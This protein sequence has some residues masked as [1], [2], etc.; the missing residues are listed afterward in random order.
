MLQFIRSVIFNIVFFGVTTFLCFALLWTLLLPRKQ[1]LSVYNMYF[2]MVYWME[3]LILGLDVKIEGLE[4]LPADNRYIIAAKHQSAHETMI[5][6]YTLNDPAII[7]KK[8]LMN[9]PFWGWYARKAGMI[10][11]DRS[12][13]GSALKSMLEGA[14]R[15]F[16]EGRPVLI[17]PQGT[18]TKLTDTTANRPY[19]RGISKIYEGLNCPV[20]PMALNTGVFWGR[21]AFIKKSG[22]ATLKFLPPIEAGLSGD[23]M[24]HRLEEALEPASTQLVDDALAMHEKQANRRALQDIAAFFVLLFGLWSAYWLWAADAV[25]KA[26]LELR[27]DMQEDA[28]LAISYGDSY[29]AGF[30]FRLRLHIEDIKLH[31]PT[32]TAHIPALEAHAVPLPDYPLTIESTAPITLSPL[33]GRA[34]GQKFVIDSLRMQIAHVIPAPFSDLAAAES[35]YQLRSMEIKSGA[36]SIQAQGH[37]HQDPQTLITNGHILFMLDGYQEYVQDLIQDGAVKAT[38]ALF[39][40]TMLQNQSAQWRRQ[41]QESGQ[42]LPANLAD[43]ALILPLSIKDNVVYAGM[44]RIGRIGGEISD[45]PLEKESG[46]G[47]GY[48]NGLPDLPRPPQD[49]EE[50]DAIPPYL[51]DKSLQG[52]DMPP[53]PAIPRND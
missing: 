9:I 16:A 23:E 2:R 3:R 15:V 30:P 38:P 8:E 24:M 35:A 13:R 14:R 45:A 48:N 25:E 28:P 39:F 18:R 31:S 22:T 20:V 47:T 44:F 52:M 42:T 34:D 36:L 11:V 32:L 53:A 12:A 6:P 19:K 49:I 26:V 33:G 50:M 41:A 37:I 27:A 7:L 46:Q 5:F 4:H 51:D 17:F 40:M 1:A 43:D 29:I 21:N 10:E